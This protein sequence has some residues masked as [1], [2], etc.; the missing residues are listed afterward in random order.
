MR[1]LITGATGFVGA[2]VARACLGSGIEVL[3]LVRDLNRGRELADRGATLA[4]GEMDRPETYEPLVNDVDAVIHAA[5]YKPGGRWTRRRISTMHRTDAR[6]TRILARACLQQQKRFIY[7]SGSLAHRGHGDE[8]I[9]EVTPLRPCLLAQGHAEMTVELQRLHA[10]QGLQ[11]MIVT[12]GF[13]YGPG[14]ILQQMIDMI[15]VEQYRLIGDGE[16]YWGLVDVDDLA[17]AFVHALLRGQAGDNYFIADDHPL[18]RRDLVRAVTDALGM[19]PV[20][21]VAPWLAG[22]WLGFPLVEA[23]R[24]SIRM[25]NGFARQRLDWKPRRSSLI[26]SLPEL[27]E[28]QAPASTGT[29][30]VGG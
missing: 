16:N 2:A 15:R 7:T 29:A 24:S 20:K 6:M 14:G 26:A 25:A 23:I 18:R 9:N 12:P 19:R 1:V 8:W 10:E 27:I 30:A 3:G 22:L 13:V 21:Q 4:V 5:Q 11:A 17:L 28:R